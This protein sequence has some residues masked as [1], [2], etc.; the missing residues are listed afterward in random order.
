[1]RLSFRRALVSMRIIYKHCNAFF[2]EE[3]DLLIH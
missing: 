1:V 3:Y 2:D